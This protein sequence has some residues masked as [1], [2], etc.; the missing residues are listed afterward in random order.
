MTTIQY[1]RATSLE[2]R[3]LLAQAMVRTAATLSPFRTDHPWELLKAL[4]GLWL[5]LCLASQIEFH[6][7]C[8][9]WSTVAQP[10]LTTPP[11]SQVQGSSNSS[12]QMEGQTS[13]IKHMLK[14]LRRREIQ[15]GRLATAQECSS[16]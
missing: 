4:E 2:T 5:C 9:G 12:P 16:Q 8:L 15:D 10:E 14:K 3:R 6:S 1:L 7:C 11:I 13:N